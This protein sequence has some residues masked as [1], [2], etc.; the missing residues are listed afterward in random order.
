MFY[1]VCCVFRDIKC[2]SIERLV[3]LVVILI[4]VYVWDEE[5][6]GFFVV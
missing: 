2:I 4:E 6:D 5:G 3:L 1:R